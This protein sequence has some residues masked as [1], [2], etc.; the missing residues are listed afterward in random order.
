MLDIS[1]PAKVLFH[2]GPVPISNSVLS[3]FLATFL[4]SV[5][6]LS[7][8]STFS[9]IP[10]KIQTLFEA[11]FDY[12]D[13]Q[14]TVAFGS[15]EDGRKFFPL[16]TTLLLYIAVSNQLSI[17]PILFQFTYDDKP[18]FRLATS[19]LSQ[20]VALSL[21]VVGLSHFLALSMA[22]L[23]HIGNYIKLG[24]ILKIRSYKDIGTVILDLFLGILDIIGELAKIMSLSCRLFG[25]L[26]AGDVMYAVIVSLSVF[27]SFVVPFPFIAI[28]F[29]GGFVQ[30]FVFMLLSMQF[31]SGQYVTAK[32]NRA[33]RLLRR[34]QSATTT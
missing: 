28:S 30:A 11:I 21:M 6:I 14:L 26:F 22:P 32:A 33:S 27:T 20:T 2:V 15:K 12:I 9:I 25:N 18:L 24:S 13:N 29:F 3:A 5:I 7:I 17:L 31:I 19:D 4:F 8:R 23:K 16:I 34:E 10:S 1:L